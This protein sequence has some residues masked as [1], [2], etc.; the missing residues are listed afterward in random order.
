MWVHVLVCMCVC[1]YEEFS[2]SV[3]ESPWIGSTSWIQWLKELSFPH[4]AIISSSQSVYKLYPFQQPASTLPSLWPVAGRASFLGCGRWWLAWLASFVPCGHPW[5][6][7]L[8]RRIWCCDWSAL[9]HMFHSWRQWVT[10]IPSNIQGLQVRES[11]VP[12]RKI[13]KNHKNVWSDKWEKRLHKQWEMST[14]NLNSEKEMEAFKV[15]WAGQIKTWRW[16]MSHMGWAESA[17]VGWLEKR[18]PK[19][20]FGAIMV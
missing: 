3:T 16:E 17:E 14:I 7:H 11:V 4:L 9:S 20:K 10:F 1:V 19:Y 2:D 12:Q 15:Q 8:V 18:A 5:A 13:S 6:S